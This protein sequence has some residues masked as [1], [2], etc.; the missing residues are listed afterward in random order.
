MA[1]GEDGSLCQGVQ[2][3]GECLMERYGWVAAAGLFG[4]VVGVW[5][6]VAATV[7][8]NDDIVAKGVFTHRNHAYRLTEI[9]GGD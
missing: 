3:E 5:F 9:K 4:L 7:K 2:D 1:Q 8:L 6:T